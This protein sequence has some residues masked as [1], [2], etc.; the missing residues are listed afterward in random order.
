M[1]DINRYDRRKLG[2]PKRNTS[3]H[4]NVS[5]FENQT[6]KENN[7][8]ILCQARNDWESLDEFRNRARRCARYV[9]GKQWDDIIR[10]PDHYGKFISEKEYIKRQ[11]KVPMVQNKI[12]SIVRNIIGQ[13]RTNADKAVVFVRDENRTDDEQMLTD[14]LQSIAASNQLEELDVQNL[15]Y[16]LLSGALIQRI[17]YSYLKK[18]DRS[19]VYI[20][21]IDY[22][23]IFFN[24]DVRDLRLNDLCRIGVIH[25]LTLDQLLSQ[26]CK[27]EADRQYLTDRFIS[28]TSITSSPKGLTGEEER[29]MDFLCSSDNTRMRVIECW[30]IE[31]GWSI[32]INDPATGSEGITELSEKQIRE[33][34]NE[35]IRQVIQWNAEH[36]DQQIPE[37]EIALV[38]YEKKI[39]PYWY[40]RYFLTDGTCLQEGKT[41]Y[42]HQ[43]HPFDLRLFPMLSG[44]VYGIVYQMLDQQRI[45]NRTVMLWDFIMGAGAKGVLMIPESAI[46]EGMTAEDYAEQW[47][48]FDGVIV[49]K[50]TKDG[51]KPE[52]ITTNSVPVGVYDMLNIQLSLI[53]D[54][55]G[56]HGAIQ[57]KNPNSGTSG[58]LYQQETQNASI[59]TLD[60]MKIHTSFKESRDRKI[61]KTALQFY[62]GKRRIISSDEHKVVTID[63]EKIRDLEFELQIIQN[64]DTPS[65]RQMTE[66]RLIQMVTSGL[67][68]AE[69]YFEN[70]SDPTSK[71]I[72]E[73][74]KKM[75][76]NASQQQGLPQE[77]PPELMQA[78]QQGNPQAVEMLQ[79]A[80]GM[81]AK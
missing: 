50:P 16:F 60:I 37:G 74:I 11:G 36:P 70:S 17:S 27:T 1:M 63:P 49:Y 22:N 73:S 7:F 75:K 23:R 13:Y 56:V 15:S 44:N 68:P 41:P 6:G 26:F 25:D 30:N 14:I 81:N 40:Y 61:L 31:T 20:E 19:D 69:L 29:H 34:N 43:E 10:D 39:E 54:I 33:V 65:Y 46:P 55:S 79:N 67:L 45:I 51:T 8:N 18:Y 62:N 80:I 32:Y 42:L 77:I 78:A 21:N 12:F 52:Q 72:Y 35:R 58:T 76:E 57:G 64:M 5:R 28:N 24:A 38:E 4:G 71:K 48:R 47:V 66:D 2:V 53:Q 59:N 9:D 3:N